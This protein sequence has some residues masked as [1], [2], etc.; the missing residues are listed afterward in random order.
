MQESK[1]T[2]KCDAS[3]LIE[4]T[5]LLQGVIESR[6]CSFSLGNL[7][8]EFVRVENDFS[9]ASA[10]EVVVRLYP[11][12]GFLR[13]AAAFLAGQFDLHVVK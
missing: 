5:K 2:M 12:D 7:G 6:N 9:S 4:F 11:S 3:P 10:G 1:I 13:F 8:F